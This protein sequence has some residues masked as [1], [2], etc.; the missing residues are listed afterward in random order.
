M[1]PFA[2][3]EGWITGRLSIERGTQL[4]QEEVLKFCI[5]GGDIDDYEVGYFRL[6]KCTCVIVFRRKQTQ[7]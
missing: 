6:N 3:N 2:V 7:A 1:K 5:M 4:T